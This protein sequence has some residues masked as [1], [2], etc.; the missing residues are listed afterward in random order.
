MCLLVIQCFNILPFPYFCSQMTSKLQNMEERLQLEY[1]QVYLLRRSWRSLAVAVQSYSLI[2]LI[3]QLS[4]ICWVSKAN[5]S[6]VPRKRISSY[7]SPHKVWLTGIFLNNMI[8]CIVCFWTFMFWIPVYP[9]NCSFL[10]PLWHSWK[11]ICLLWF[12]NFSYNNT[13]YWLHS[14]FAAPKDLCCGH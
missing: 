13:W 2:L 1:V 5:L 14:W 10:G 12:L 8:F 7:N 3:A 9:W 6:A 4:W 11:E